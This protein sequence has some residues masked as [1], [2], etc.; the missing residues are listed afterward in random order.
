LRE[1]AMERYLIKF[2][3]DEG[4]MVEISVVAP[5]DLEGAEQTNEAYRRARHQVAM[6]HR[7]IGNLHLF[8]CEKG[9]LTDIGW[10]KERDAVVTEYT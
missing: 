1:D 4:F 10:V 3:T 9:V 8:S 7:G 2:M 6:K 5:V